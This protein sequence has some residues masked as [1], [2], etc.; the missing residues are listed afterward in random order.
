MIDYNPRQ[1]LALGSFMFAARSGFKPPVVDGKYTIPNTLGLNGIRWPDPDGRVVHY[2]RYKDTLVIS[3]SEDSLS[4]VLHNNLV[5]DCM[6]LAKN[7]CTALMSIADIAKDELLMA[8]L[9]GSNPTLAVGDSK[10]RSN[11][12]EELELLRINNPTL[13]KDRFNL[14]VDALKPIELVLMDDGVVSLVYKDCVEYA[15]QFGELTLERHGIKLTNVFKIVKPGATYAGRH[16][17]DIYYERITE[18]T[19]SDK[20]IRIRTNRNQ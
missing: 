7:Y 12:I 16:F 3:Y 19:D 18:H 15:H 9:A 17:N 20:L 6:T 2:I 4:Q 8:L 11:K 1:A 5:D 10:W 14:I 13:S